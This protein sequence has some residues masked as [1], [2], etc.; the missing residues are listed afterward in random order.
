MR[1]EKKLF[2]VLTFPTTTAAM[3]MEQY[4]LQNAIPGRHIPVPGQISAGCGIAWRMK[5]E[6]Y[7]QYK[8]Q[9]H[10]SAVPMQQETEVWLY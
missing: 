2:V 5:K 8:E 1:R 10:T 7:A 4:C 6:D 9:L 3:A